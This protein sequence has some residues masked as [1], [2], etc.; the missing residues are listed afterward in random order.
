[1]W[2]E[3]LAN[4]VADYG[5]ILNEVAERIRLQ[6]REGL[7]LDLDKAL[8]GYSLNERT[9][10]VMQRFAEDYSKG[11]EREIAIKKKIHQSLPSQGGIK[12]VYAL[13]KG[14]SSK[15]LAGWMALLLFD[16]RY[17]SGYYAAKIDLKRERR[18]LRRRIRKTSLELAYYWPL[19]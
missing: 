19:R 13:L 5:V 9:K 1:M 15:G 12:R 17:I 7:Q 2:L 14:A 18:G 6:Y 8:E 10:P 3:D 4:R 11:F 16:E